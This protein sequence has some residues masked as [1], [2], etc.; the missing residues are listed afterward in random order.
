MFAF[1]LAV[2]LLARGGE[3]QQ[4]LSGDK[5]LSVDFVYI[6]DNPIQAQIEDDVRLSLSNQGISDLLVLD[7]VWKM[8][9]DDDIASK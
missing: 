1:V 3:A 4:R 5:K 6:N 8:T 2:I 7:G 9:L